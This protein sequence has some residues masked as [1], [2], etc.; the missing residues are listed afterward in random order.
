[1][2][3]QRANKKT[4]LII[5]IIVLAIG[6]ST[7]GALYYIN[8]NGSSED[9]TA[10]PTKAPSDTRQASELAEDAD[11]KS[12]SPNS[13]QP[14]EPVLNEETGKKTVQMIASAN[15]S[16][17]SL[18]IRGGLNYPA[19]E[20]GSCFAVLTSPTGAT[21]QKNTTVLHN[22]ASADCKTISVPVSE[23]SSGNWK[24]VLKFTSA[25]YE[26]TSNEAA[27]TIN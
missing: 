4:L 27:F 1:M 10:V 21:I 26:G 3:I 20:D 2:K 15:V 17:G 11:N 8:S 9:K 16:G 23:L 18:Y 14:N 5:L 19:P 13:D 6:A 7:A 25:N 12:E 24:V 22:P